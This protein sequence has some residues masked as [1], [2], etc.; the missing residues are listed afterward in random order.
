MGMLERV[1]TRH[2]VDEAIEGFGRREKRVRALP[3]HGR[4]NLQ[5]DPQGEAQSAILDGL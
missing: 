1:F 4:G 5:T 3:D 2:L